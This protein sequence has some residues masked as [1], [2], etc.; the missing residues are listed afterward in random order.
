M[1]LFDQRDSKGQ[2]QSISSQEGLPIDHDIPLARNV[3]NQMPEFPALV[4]PSNEIWN[5]LDKIFVLIYVQLHAL[6]ANQ[7]LQL[8]AIVFQNVLASIQYFVVEEAMQIPLNCYESFLWTKKQL[9]IFLSVA[10][11]SSLLTYAQQELEWCLQLIEFLMVATSLLQSGP[12]R[13][14]LK[15]APMDII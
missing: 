10:G 11:R 9:A 15:G 1:D 12:L 14:E 5:I 2:M 8:Y 4:V 3:L 6:P 13:P 7:E